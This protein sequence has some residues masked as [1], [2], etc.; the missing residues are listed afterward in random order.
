MFLFLLKNL[1]RKGLMSVMGSN[2]PAKQLINLAGPGIGKIGAS[3]H[4]LIIPWNKDFIQS[5]RGEDY[6]K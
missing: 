6:D 5:E 2:K 3:L 1:A 4:T